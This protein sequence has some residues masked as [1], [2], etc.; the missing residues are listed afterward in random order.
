MPPNTFTQWQYQ[1][2]MGQQQGG[3]P[4]SASKTYPIRNHLGPEPWFRSR[5]DML[6]S[7]RIPTA[8]YP[9][10]YLGTVRSR[11]RDRLR[12]EGGGTRLTQRN[13]QRGVHVGARVEPQQY[14]WSEE[15][16]P[17]KGMELQLKGQKFA[18]Q[19][20]LHSHLI[21]DGKP[22]PQP[23]MSVTHYDEY[24]KATYRKL[25]PGWR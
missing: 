5:K 22:R 20:E 11:V 10:G 6:L 12:A 23:G 24:L 4:G 14:F 7:A 17:E 3:V 16:Y 19:G 13:Y 15:V 2:P 9:D 21:N 25:A 18:P 1:D 8:Q